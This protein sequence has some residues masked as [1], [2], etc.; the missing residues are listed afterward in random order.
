MKKILSVILGLA[1]S[2]T[3]LPSTPVFAEKDITV[4]LD[5]QK[6][7]F[8]VNPEIIDGRTL[9]PLRKIFEEIGAMVKWNDDTQTVSARKNSKTITLTI[10]SA[11]LQIDKGKT[12]DDGNPII[13]T[14]TLEVPA[15]L[16]SGR[17]LVPVRAISESFGLNVEWDD[18]N[19]KVIIVSDDEEDASWNEN[20]GSINLTSLDYEGEGIE[21]SGKQIKI[22]SGGDFTLTGTL[23]DGNITISAKEKVKL[24]LNGAKITSGSNPCI[25]VED[26]DK[27]YI[28]LTEGTENVLIAENSEDGAIYSK[29]NLEIKGNGSL[30]IESKAGHGIK[31]SDNLN[32]EN[33]NITINATSDGIHINDTFKMTG[34]NVNITAVGDGIDCESI[35]NISDGTINI[36]TNG[37][38]VETAQTENNTPR[39]GMWQEVQD[40]EFEKSTKGINA[41]WMMSISGGEI[42]I[43][44]ASHTIHCQDEIEINGGK[45]TLSSKYDKGISA[46]GNLTING[47]DTSI[48]ISKSTEGLESKN[49]MTINDG[50]INVISSDDAVNATGGKSGM[51]MP[52]RNFGGKGGEGGSFTPPEGFGRGQKA[53]ADGT[54]KENGETRPRAPRNR[55]NRF[56]NM[57]TESENTQNNESSSAPETNQNN[58]FTPP[59][60][61]T[62]NGEFTPPERMFGNGEFTPPE[63]MFGNGEFTPPEGMFGN[64]EFTPPEGMFNGGFMGGRGNMK[65]CLIINGGYL[66]L[67]GNDDCVDANGTM[68]INGGTI[69]ASN[70]TGSF[71]GNFGVLDADGQITIS[72]N[73]NII[74]ASKSGSEKNLKLTQNF[75]IVYCENQ[76]SANEQIS[77]K[78][79]NGNI[80]YEYAPEGDFKTVLIASQ[81]IKTGKKYSITIGSETFEA[82]ISGQSTIVGTQSTTT[83]MGFVRGNRMQ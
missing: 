43:N 54:A 40:V 60:G 62:E 47:A 50:I 77:V 6:I 61:M 32:I 30:E 8:D 12:D 11:D 21:I 38:P 56:G 72:E 79:N 64:G 78:D 44:S 81:N 42:N 55:N 53:P 13:E 51:M 65:T 9:V 25:F 33:G 75:I 18:E 16:S 19:Q 26:A 2:A 36:E 58:R 20:I 83:G 41:E 22:T 45:F 23:T 7:E 10:D 59:S 70:P 68:A 73:A 46:H 3:L 5:G 39:R 17:T 80:V 29:E 74:L 35:V 37:T 4:E 48:D 31:A 27:A 57:N 63:G 52:G 76:H 69:K 15:Q 24:R 34:G 1:M 67:C 66:E 49:V 28:T 82:E 71:T 14:V